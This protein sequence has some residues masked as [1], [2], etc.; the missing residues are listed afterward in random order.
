[1]SNPPP[2]YWA[3]CRAIL[4]AWSVPAWTWFRE[5]FGIETVGAAAAGVMGGLAAYGSGSETGG[6]VTAALAAGVLSFALIFATVFIASWLGARYRVWNKQ[7][8]R[9][10]ELEARLLPGF[11][12]GWYQIH[13]AKINERLPDGSQEEYESKYI[14]LAIMNKGPNPI[15]CRAF[16]TYAERRDHQGVWQRVLSYTIPLTWSATMVADLKLDSLVPRLLNVMRCSQPRNRLEFDTPHFSVPLSLPPLFANLGLYRLTVC[17][18][19]DG[20][21]TQEL[22]VEV[23]NT[24]GW[25]TFAVTR[26]V[27]LPDADGELDQETEI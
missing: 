7:A 10:S 11:E 9:I 20:L 5:K 25:H 16:L 2:T 19:S 17:V 3:Y 23:N 18:V 27:S 1:V 22:V 15:I 12:V 8:Q 4:D 26:A 24:K 13:V 21:P 6:I 14:Q